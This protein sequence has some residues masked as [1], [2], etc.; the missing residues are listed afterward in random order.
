MSLQRL[1]LW[2]SCVTM[3]CTLALV[4]AQTFPNKPIK[5]VIP[6]TT[7][8]SDV[9]ARALA[10]R[11]SSVLGQSVVVEQMPGAG[12]NIGNNFVAKSAPDGYTLLING[13]PLVTNLA[14]YS[15]L[16]YNPVTDLVPVI[17]LADVNNVITVH[18]SLGVQS[19]KELVQLAKSKPG[20]LNYGSP[21]AGSSGHLSAEMLG[22]KT[23][24]QMV[25]FPYKGNSQA[26]MDLLR[27]E[28][29]VGFLNLPMALPQV[30]AG[31]LKALA[32]TGAKRSNL[33]PDVPTV[34]EAL[35]MPDF[36]LTAWFVIMA[37]AKTPSSV[38]NLLNKEIDKI[39]KDP[40]FV[41]KIHNAGA[42]VI[43]GS[44]ASFEARMKKDAARLSELIKLAGTKAEP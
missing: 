23:G 40:D 25:H 12:T 39:L 5:L 43:G 13:L 4:S 31:K 11:L 19:L 35:G 3:A 37:P 18:P 27:G 34:A 28:L 41:E 24:A 6:A 29:Q 9:I 10:P 36:E 33:L 30:K 42:E 16:P 7:G 1:I 2:I 32:V 20:Q 14:L 15:Q 21:G 8:T 17:G 22:L 38:V 44:A 26:T